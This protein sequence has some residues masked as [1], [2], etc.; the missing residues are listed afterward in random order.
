MQFGFYNEFGDWLLVVAAYNSGAG[1]VYNAIKKSG[2]RNFWKLQYFLPAE[3]R[4][5]VKRFIG[6]HCYFQD[7][8]SLTMLT[9]SETTTYLK[10]VGDFKVKQSLKVDEQTIIAVR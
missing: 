5:H 8:N 9:K 1:P 2:S 4:G 3:T 7:E 10:A 6:T